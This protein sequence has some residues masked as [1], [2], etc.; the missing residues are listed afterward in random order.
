M[1]FLVLHTVLYI[2]YYASSNT[3][4]DQYIT[5]QQLNPRHNLRCCNPTQNYHRRYCHIF[6]QLLFQF[7]GFQF[8]HLGFGFQCIRPCQLSCQYAGW[9]SI[10]ARLR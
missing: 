8:R 9:V 2:Y 7:R 4:I 1:V 3:D 6:V 10:Q 5:S